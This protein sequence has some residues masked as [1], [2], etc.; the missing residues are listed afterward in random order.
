MACLM[1][2]MNKGGKRNEKTSV[3]KS[4]KNF[5]IFVIAIFSG[6][7]FGYLWKI[8]VEG[9]V[10]GILTFWI[11]RIFFDSPSLYD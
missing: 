3:S 4:M 7:V 2:L 8:G 11:V 6:I 5:V 10:I 1:K 9:E